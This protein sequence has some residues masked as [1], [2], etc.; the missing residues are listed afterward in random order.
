M[1]YGDLTTLVQMKHDKSVLTLRDL[2]ACE[3][4]GETKKQ[5]NFV[6]VC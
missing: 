4:R 2:T 3:W 5:P 6:S 1:I